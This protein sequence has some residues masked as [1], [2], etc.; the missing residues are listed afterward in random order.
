MKPW[1]LSQLWENIIQEGL[2][3]EMC[4]DRKTVHTL[5]C[6]QLRA[7]C[8]DNTSPHE[9]EKKLTC[10]VTQFSM[11]AVYFVRGKTELHLIFFLSGDS[12]PPSYLQEN[13]LLFYLAHRW[14]TAACVED[15]I[16][17]T[18][19]WFFLSFK[20]FPKALSRISVAVFFPPTGSQICYLNAI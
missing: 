20:Y 4:Q 19:H 10:T 11:F 17:N 12:F 13:K 14:C 15:L 5:H 6:C 16:P 9:Q 8:A 18:F 2:Q 1:Q 3:E 7:S